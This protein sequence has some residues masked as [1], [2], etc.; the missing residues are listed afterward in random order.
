[1]AIKK[2][3]KKVV[4]K[5]K[6]SKTKEEKLEKKSEKKIEHKMDGRKLGN[7]V[8]FSVKDKVVNGKKYNY[9]TTVDGQSFLLSDEDFKKQV[10][11]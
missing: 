8:V 5:K 6:E 2:T 3:D 9:V 4:S 11:G 1:M 7:T 10:R